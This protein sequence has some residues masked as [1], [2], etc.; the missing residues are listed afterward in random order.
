[1]RLYKKG[2]EFRNFTIFALSRRHR[3]G[4]P[5]ETIGQGSSERWGSSGGW[6]RWRPHSEKIGVIILTI[7]LK[8]YLNTQIGK[9]RIFS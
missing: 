4:C 2:D 7:H 3:W 9:I 8:R 1:M 5:G 6:H